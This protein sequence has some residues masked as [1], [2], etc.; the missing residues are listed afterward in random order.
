MGE[1]T[2]ES[3]ELFSQFEVGQD[4]ADLLGHFE[5]GQ[6]SVDL[7]ARFE[8]GQDAEEFL[9]R[10]AIRRSASSDLKFSLYVCP[11]YLTAVEMLVGGRNR[12]MKIK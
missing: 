9:G 5:V 11:W 7:P 1:F 10:V 6:D 12:R 4:S 8:V 3:A 2:V